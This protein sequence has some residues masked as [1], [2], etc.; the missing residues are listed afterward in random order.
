MFITSLMPS[1]HLILWCPLL[2][3][4][5]FPSIRDFSNESSVHWS[6]SIS[7]SSEYSGLISIKINW[8]D[9]LAVQGT[10]G[11]LLPHHSLRALILWHS[12][13]FTVQLSQLCVNTGKTIALMIWMF[14]GR[15]MSLLFNTLSSF[16]IT[17]LPRSNHPLVSRLQ[18]PS[19]VIL[20]PEK[21]KSVTT[22]TFSLSICHTVMGLDA[23]I[24]VLTFSLKPALSLS[25]F[26]LKRLF[27]SSLLSAIRVVSSSCLRLLMF[28]PPILIP[29]VAHPAWH[30][31]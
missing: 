27:S 11:S 17:F 3:L 21:R 26:T 22:S 16:L 19:T 30:F 31:S 4:S 29:L 18:Q 23:M 15:V 10:F 28:L 2:L 9:L 12:A 24:L 6:F 25:F 8:F 20:E 5:V 1:G 13:F 7:P 14:V